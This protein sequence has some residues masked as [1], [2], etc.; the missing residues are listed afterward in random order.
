MDI[1]E[2]IEARIAEEEQRAQALGGGEWHAIDLCEEGIAILD[3]PDDG[4]PN[5]G[6]SYHP[7]RNGHTAQITAN[8]PPATLLRCAGLRKV[9]ERAGDIGHECGDPSASEAYELMILVPVATIWSSHPSF[10]SEW[11]E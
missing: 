9:V 5:A 10:R 8:S 2:F 7:P 11:V 6:F 1:A 4:D 3:G